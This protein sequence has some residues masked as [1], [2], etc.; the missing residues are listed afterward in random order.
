VK[1]WAAV[2]P[3]VH[4][5]VIFSGPEVA[6]TYVS[7]SRTL[8]KQTVAYP[9]LGV[10]CIFSKEEDSDTRCDADKP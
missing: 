5:S 4:S 8:D 1:L 3:Q 10:P 6:T 7:I 2:V 9:R